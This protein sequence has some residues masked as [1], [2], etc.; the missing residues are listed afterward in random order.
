MTG[1]TLFVQAEN[2]WV[3]TEAQGYDPDL[4]IDGYSRLL[5]TLRP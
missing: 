5:N 1:F 2:L 4:Q 3:W